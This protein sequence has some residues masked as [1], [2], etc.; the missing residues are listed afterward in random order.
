MAE[1][2]PALQDEINEL[3]TRHTALV[4]A[5]RNYS[6]GSI[7]QATN[8]L[9]AAQ[10]QT[11]STI[12]EREAALLGLIQRNTTK[13]VPSLLS[14]FATR[15]YMTGVRRLEHG[16]GVH[17]MWGIS[18]ASSR[19]VWGASGKLVEVGVDEAAYSYDPETG[20][21]RGVSVEPTRTNMVA[22]SN[23]L[24]GWAT[25]RVAVT[26]NVEMG[27]DGTEKVVPTLIPDTEDNN[28]FIYWDYFSV[29][30]DTTYTISAW[31]EDENY[32]RL[33]FIFRS[34]IGTAPE[35]S[36]LSLETIEESPGWKRLGYTF[37]TP[38]D[39]E[40]LQVRLYLYEGSSITYPGDGETGT[41]MDECV[42]EEGRSASTTIP[43]SGSTVTRDAD[44]VR[45]TLGDEYNPNGFSVYADAQ[46]RSD[47]GSVFF[48]NSGGLSNSMRV[49]LPSNG[50]NALFVVTNGNIQ[51]V[52]PLADFAGYTPGDPAKILLA[53]DPANGQVRL[54]INGE[55]VTRN[56]S[57]FPKLDE[58]RIGGVSG[59]NNNINGTVHDCI[60]YPAAISQADAE[61]MAP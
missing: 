22:N 15:T 49:G 44:V 58:K 55:T 57:E 42:V 28:H 60:M 21:P 30:P 45:R 40:D 2:D 51:A 34:S 9:L 33:R 54:T 14:D 16:V 23:L 38:S 19:L 39:C 10:A 6:G 48:L 59:N 26:T 47:I 3:Q 11:E 13:P 35:N 56:V 61:A 43:T 25:S 1:L 8:D 32:H 31:V 50:D 20:S 12:D 18:R 29:S 27:Y 37:T 53:V 5:V 4:D 52:I 7:A 24:N 41:R 17:D 46:Q 36:S